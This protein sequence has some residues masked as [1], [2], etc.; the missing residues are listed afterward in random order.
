MCI[1]SRIKQIRIVNG[2]TQDQL[3]ERAGI[4]KQAISL[5][6]R[7]ESKKTFYLVEIAAALGTTAE[8]LKTGKKKA[9]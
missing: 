9:A 6:E 7:G 8:Y 2:I 3:A 4:T 1:G 5:L